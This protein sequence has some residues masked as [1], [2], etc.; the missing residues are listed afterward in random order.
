MGEWCL[1]LVYIVRVDLTINKDLIHV[2]L[3][4][5][6]TSGNIFITGHTYWQLHLINLFIYNARIVDHTDHCL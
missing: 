2:H 1:F 3:S 4:I 5:K 6:V